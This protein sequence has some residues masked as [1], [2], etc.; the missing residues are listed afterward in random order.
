MWHPNFD[1]KTFIKLYDREMTALFPRSSKD[2]RTSDDSPK[3]KEPIA[4]LPISL[5]KLVLRFFK[6]K[7]IAS[8]S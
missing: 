7:A 5:K 4:L 1:E 3:A 6:F 8:R 2:N